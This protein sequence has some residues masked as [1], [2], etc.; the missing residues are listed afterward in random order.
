MPSI[1]VPCSTVTYALITP[2]RN[3]A[4]LIEN[5]I[6][7]V[8]AQIVRPVR[9]IIVS[10]GS[11]DGTDEI[12]KRYAAVHS[13]IELLR[14]PE[15]RDRQ[16]AAKAHAF[17]AGYAHL[18]GGGSLPG[19][20]LI[21][22]LDADITFEPGYYAFL[23]SKFADR[24]QLGVAGTPFVED[25]DRLHTHTYDHANANLNHVSGA[26]QLFRRACFE[27]VGGYVPVKGGAI[28]WIAVTTARMKGWET[29]TF[30]EKVCFHHRKLGT[31]SGATGQLRMR[32]HYGK[33]AYYVGGHPVWEI[34]RGMFAMRR[35]P[36]ILGGLSFIAGYLCA[37]LARI[38]RPVSA[39]LIAFHRGEQMTRL[40][41]S[42]GFGSRTVLPAS[43]EMTASAR[44]T[45]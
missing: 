34:S 35:K 30:T 40:W 37:A 17:N 10:D 26:V 19:F 22:N 25:F 45:T 39:E 6:K 27:Q 18:I 1:I 21:G 15:R 5:T 43:D 7:S 20:D 36:L 31:G 29:R 8:V 23:L 41:R 32:F 3:E 44:T 2:A 11:T 14:L 28:D 38:E 12:V 13:W 9:W 24:P 42:F 4:D 16:F 33:K